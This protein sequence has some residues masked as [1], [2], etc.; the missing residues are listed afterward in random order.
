MSNGMENV[1][2]KEHKGNYGDTKNASAN[3]LYKSYKSYVLSKKKQPLAF[4]AWIAWAK[5]NGILPNTFSAE[6]AKEE[7]EESEVEKVA[8]A[9]GRSTKVVVTV[10]VVSI[11]LYLAYN[12]FTQTEDKPKS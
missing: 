11:A 10:I 1:E 2:V 4:P 5:E 9:V 7:V 8:E 12:L 6:G 3:K